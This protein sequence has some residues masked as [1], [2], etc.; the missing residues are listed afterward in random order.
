MDEQYFK[1]SLEDGSEQLCKVVFTFDTDDFSY[2]LYSIVDEDGNESE[3]ITALRYEVDEDGKMTHFTPLETEEEW[4]MVE[5]VLN[6]L[7]AEFGDEDEADYFTISDENGEEIEC[8]VLH[9]FELKDFNKSYI[10]Y[11]FADQDEDGEIFVAAYIAGENGEVEE[12]LPIESDEE[13]AKVEK[14]LEFINQ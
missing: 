11:T 3:E 7:I 13:W 5:E 1:V 4:D 9:R 14:E 6:T 12:L 10:L 8:E 2:V